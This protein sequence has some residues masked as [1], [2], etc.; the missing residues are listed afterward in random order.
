[1]TDLGIF[2]IL[3]EI[4]RSEHGALIM[5]ILDWIFDIAKYW[6]GKS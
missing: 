5:E 3:I 2:D 6:D 4:I 1:M